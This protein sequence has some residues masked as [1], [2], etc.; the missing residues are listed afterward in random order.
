MLEF[1]GFVILFFLVFRLQK[2]V[3]LLKRELFFSNALLKFPKRIPPKYRCKP[4]I[5]NP[6]TGK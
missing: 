3:D 6:L 2:D 1:I 4:H 5:F